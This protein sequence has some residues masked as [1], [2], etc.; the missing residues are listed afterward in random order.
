MGHRELLLTLGAIITFGILTLRIN[1]SVVKSS[2]AV[3]GQQA[4]INALS[5]AQQFIEEAKLKAFDENTVAGTVP[6]E[7]GFTNAG[8]LGP[9]GGALDDIDDYDGTNTSVPTPI[10]NMN[11]TITVHYVQES[12]LETSVSSRTYYKKMT[13]T[14]QTAYLSNPVSAEYVFAFHKN[15]L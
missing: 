9:E 2:E 1:L 15:L 11:V 10:G 7:T 6:N 12:D 4:E 8:S 5:L 3:Y 14:V 13:V